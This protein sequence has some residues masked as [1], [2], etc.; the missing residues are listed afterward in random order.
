MVWTAGKRQAKGRADWLKHLDGVPHMV[1][2]KTARDCRPFVF[3]AQCAK[4]G[5]HLQFAF[6]H[7]GYESITGKRPRMIEIVVENTPPHAVAVYRI[8]GDVLEQGRDEYTQLLETLEFCES[9]NVWP[10]PAPQEQELTLPTW[11]YAAGDD[12]VEGLGLIGVDE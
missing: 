8:G 3:G 1:G 2:L 11:A 6:Y 9:G 12:D 7:D 4:L 10:G 5:Y